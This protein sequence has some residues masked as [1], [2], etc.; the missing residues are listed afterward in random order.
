MSARTFVYETGVT[1]PYDDVIQRQ[2]ASF[3]IDDESEKQVR[4]STFF[5]P[6]R[7]TRQVDVT[8]EWSAPTFDQI[9]TLTVFF[10]GTTLVNIGFKYS[11]FF[12]GRKA[13]IARLYGVTQAKVTDE[14]KVFGLASIDEDGSPLFKV[15][16]VTPINA[17]L[18]I[19]PKLLSNSLSYEM[20]SFQLVQGVDDTVLIY[21]IPVSSSRVFNSLVS[22]L[23]LDSSQ[24]I[25]LIKVKA[26]T[27]TYFGSDLAQVV[28]T[29]LDS[30]KH[31]LVVKPYN[32]LYI[33]YISK[34]IPNFNSVLV[35]DGCTLTDK[36]QEVANSSYSVLKDIVG[37]G[38]LRYLLV[39]L[40]FGVWDVRWLLNRYNPIFYKGLL[41]S[42]Y[43]NQYPI[44]KSLSS[45]DVYFR[46]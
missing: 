22:R 31:S 10:V 15:I 40:V 45:A 9:K 19:R 29:I 7:G 43:R 30:K 14:R 42:R 20:I 13:K 11:L 6:N 3:N 2:I 8:Y 44:V 41:E 16:F 39:W 5:D 26:T 38:T 35:G 17:I 1:H 36:V 34:Y 25:P 46:R 28:Y 18:T 24:E 37:Y 33:S 4:A 12:N 23:S 27:D 32:N 21:P